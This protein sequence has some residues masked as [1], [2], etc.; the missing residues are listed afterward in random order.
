MK[1][2]VCWLE[3]YKVKGGLF[4]GVFDIVELWKLN[5]SRCEGYFNKIFFLAYIP[6]FICVIPYT[7]LCLLEGFITWLAV[8]ILKRRKINE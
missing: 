1:A 3:K 2:L 8:K 7:M 6:V 5:S 4:P